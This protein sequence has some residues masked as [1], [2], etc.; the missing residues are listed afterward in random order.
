MD[1]QAEK[2]ISSMYLD[3]VNNFLTVDAFAQYYY[4]PIDE[5]R[6]VIEQG[7][8]IQDNLQAQSLMQELYTT[9]KVTGLIANRKRS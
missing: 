2:V 5:A 8:E 4:L 7:R 1:N 3:Y 6:Q 9:K